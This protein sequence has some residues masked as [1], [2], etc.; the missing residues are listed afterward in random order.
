MSLEAK[1]ENLTTVIEKLIAVLDNGAPATPAQ[2]KTEKAQSRKA[3]VEPEAATE[4]KEPDAD[5]A[6]KPDGS[7]ATQA[8]EPADDKPETIDYKVVADAINTRCA[9][10]MNKAVKAVLLQFGANNGK[11][12]KAEQYGVF[13]ATLSAEVAL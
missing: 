1:I 10:G 11:E 6:P 13:L 9:Q 8:S 4:T 12:L 2:P 5:A 3:R 7:T